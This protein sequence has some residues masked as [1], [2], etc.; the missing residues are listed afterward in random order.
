MAAQ[1]YCLIRTPHFERVFNWVL[2]NSIPYELHANRLR[3]RPH[4]D[5][6]LLQYHLQYSDLCA[7]V[8]LPYPTEF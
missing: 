5:S 4:S 8:E 6:L 3:F 1:Y 7:P 2:D